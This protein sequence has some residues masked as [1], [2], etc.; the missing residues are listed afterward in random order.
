M[1][2]TQHTVRGTA[3]VGVRNPNLPADVKSSLL[4]PPDSGGSTP[5]ACQ[6]GGGYGR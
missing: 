1:P 3:D 4:E 5:D 2:L 6:L